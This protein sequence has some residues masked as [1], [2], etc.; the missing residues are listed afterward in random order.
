MS[1]AIARNDL[2]SL[3]LHAGSEE[4]YI[5][6]V[7]RIPTLSAEE[8]QD[9]AARY[10]DDNDLDAAR[11]LVMSHLRFVVHVARGYTGYGLPLADLIQEGN[12]GLMKA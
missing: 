12:I 4:H 11:Y 9:L 2:S 10:R 5:Q 1:K 8:E 6:A 3:P 7:N